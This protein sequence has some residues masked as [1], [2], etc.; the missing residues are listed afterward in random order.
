MNFDQ[1][2]FRELCQQASS[3]LDFDEV[4]EKVRLAMSEIEGAT[5][6]APFIRERLVGQGQLA[7]TLMEQRRTDPTQLLG[8]LNSYLSRSEIN[9]NEF[10]ALETWF[11]KVAYRPDA[12]VTDELISKVRILWLKDPTFN[13]PAKIE[14]AKKRLKAHESFAR[15]SVDLNTTIGSLKG[16]ERILE[17]YP[18]GSVGTE[19]LF[20]R[21]SKAKETALQRRGTKLEQLLEDAFTSYQTIVDSS[22]GKLL[23]QQASKE[24]QLN[25]FGARRVLEKGELEENERQKFSE[26]LDGI[27]ERFDKIRYLSSTTIFKREYEPYLNRLKDEID[28]TVNFADMVDELN[29]IQSRSRSG[30][31]SGVDRLEKHH[32]EQVRSLVDEVKQELRKRYENREALLREIR[33]AAEQVSQLDRRPVLTRRSVIQ[34]QKYLKT[35]MT[36]ARDLGDREAL[37]ELDTLTEACSTLWDSIESRYN[38]YVESFAASLADFSRQIDSHDNFRSAYEELEEL[39]QSIDDSESGLHH[40]DRQRLLAQFS[41]VRREFNARLDNVSEIHRDFEVLDD[42][43]GRAARNLKRYSNFDDLEA[44]ARNIGFRVGK[45]QF[46]ASQKQELIS[47]V[48]R[49]YARLEGL[50]KKREQH[51]AERAAN[52]TAVF[53]EL[54][55]TIGECQRVARERPGDQSSWEI[56][57]DA[58]HQLRDERILDKDQ[59]ETLRQDL[60]VAFASIKEE[61]ARFAREAS[62]VYGQYLD[63]IQNILQ[64]LERSSPRPSR[65]DA[66]EA[67][68]AVKP[69]RARLRDEERLLRGHRQ[70]LFSN[71]RVISDAISE[72][73]DRASEDMQRNLV[74]MRRRIDALRQDIQ[75]VQQSSQIQQAIN[76]HKALYADLRTQ[77][78]SVDGRREFRGALEELWD[79]ITEK[80]QEFGRSRFDPGRIDDTL[81]RLENQG[82]FL[83]M[84][85]I[86]RIN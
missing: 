82:H 25:I 20:E 53:N 9:A 52:Q 1:K 24:L 21:L 84:R 14:D 60:E 67:I 85:S 78:L 19:A 23:D 18:V 36:W 57:V 74:H 86:P 26:K 70:E 37:Q 63:A 79:E 81:S 61:R 22:N 66:F 43:L 8:T 50:K 5:D 7:L 47:Q 71:L 56:L 44:E 54:S 42:K 69:L 62:L 17:S 6:L 15:T 48:R 55:E 32:Q 34:T 30:R 83:W 77:E 46:S 39:R 80:K 4:S 11:I 40:T 68:E 59:H 65:E 58:D 41:V 12:V 16:L 51:L 35:C 72:I 76:S 27:E 64:P 31:I 38:A 3:T 73:L 33:L 75:A 29:S 28:H 10:T 13:L 2:E 49:F 45:G